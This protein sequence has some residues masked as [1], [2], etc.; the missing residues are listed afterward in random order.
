MALTWRPDAPPNYVKLAVGRCLI[1]TADF[2]TWNELALLTDTKERLDRHP[3]LLRSLNFGDDYD[4]HVH[5]FVP[6]VLHEKEDP[7]GDPWAT[8]AYLAA[9]ANWTPLERFPLLEDVSEFLSLPAWLTENDPKLFERLFVDAE[10]DA[11][12]PDGT[13][14][15]AAETAAARLEVAEMRRQVDR[16]R[17]DYADDP[18]SAVGQAKDLI[19]TVCKTILGM[20]GETDGTVK[21]PSL[22]KQTYLHLGIDPTQVSGD[23]VE[24]R[25][26]RELIGGVTR[27]LNATDTLRNARG[28]GHGRS[29]TPLIDDAVARLAVG[30]VLAAVVYLAEIYELRT[31]QAVP[32][33]TTLADTSSFGRA[34]E[35]KVGDFVQHK[36]FGEGRVRGVVGDPDNQ[37][38]EVDFGIEVGTKRLLLKYAVLRVVR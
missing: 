33:A 2:G 38:A 13:V 24:G 7:K 32:L 23:T 18:E 34:T 37:I 8:E 10:A 30:L 21:F 6:V 15:S 25:A 11:T 17:R 36:T 27:I 35:V 1:A 16:I 31:G 14:L 3:R 26:A 29:G 28:T 12:L 19:E 20:T 22:V 5:D 4:G 9:A